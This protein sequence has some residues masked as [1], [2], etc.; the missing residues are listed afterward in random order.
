MYS[1][2]FNFILLQYKLSA[3][4][5]IN[6]Y[7]GMCVELHAIPAHAC[8]IK[9][10]SRKMPRLAEVFAKS[11]QLHYNVYIGYVIAAAL[12]LPRQNVKSNICF[13]NYFDD[14]FLSEFQQLLLNF[15]H[16]WLGGLI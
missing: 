6:Q 1:E 4:H 5:M 13:G 10:L 8:S 12:V 9:S 16:G 7:G 2:G 11:E 3:T 15:G 14:T